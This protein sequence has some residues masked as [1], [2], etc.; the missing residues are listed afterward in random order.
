MAAIMVL[1]MIVGTA[2]DMAPTILILTPVLMPL[3]NAAAS[4]RSTSACCS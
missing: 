1:V 2:L 4:T 3:V